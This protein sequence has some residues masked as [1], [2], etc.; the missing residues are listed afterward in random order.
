MVYFFLNYIDSLSRHGNLTVFSGSTFAGLISG[1]T[2]F[3]LIFYTALIVSFVWLISKLHSRE[4]LRTRRMLHELE[5]ELAE[6]RAKL[7]VLEYKTQNIADSLVYAKHIQDAL[8]PHESFLKENF[9]EYFIFYQPR[10]I[11]SG[12]F[13][14]FGRVNG[15]IYIIS[16]DCTGHGVPGALLSII[17]QNLLNQ[18]I[19]NGVVD[20]PS[21]ILEYLDKSARK[22]YTRKDDAY[23]KDGMDI[24]ICAI[25]MDSRRLEFSGAF[26]SV[27]IVR[28]DK[29]TE[30]RGNKFILGMKPEGAS[31]S[32]QESALAGNDVIYFFT[33]GYA[34]QFGGPE[35]KKFMYRR[36][37]YLLTTINRLSLPEQKVILHDT[38][39]SWKGNNE[40]VDDILVIGVRI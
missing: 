32:C 36:F 9:R 37:R 39:L 28:D 27:Y 35:N 6:T 38:F 10:D 14:W 13:Y 20:N 34:D 33:D 23:I 30:I 19:G 2:P 11:V 40:Q 5:S 17:G 12:D 16:A 26:S 25:D 29:L 18:I 31:Y 8:L 22:V 21:E 24:G 7:S 15:K 1:L 4:L 3:H